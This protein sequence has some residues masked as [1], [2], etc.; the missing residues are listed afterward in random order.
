MT[1]QE[2]IHEWLNN[3]LLALSGKRNAVRTEIKTEAE[4]ELLQSFLFGDGTYNGLINLLEYY[5]EELNRLKAS[6]FSYPALHNGVGSTQPTWETRFA[7]SVSVLGDGENGFYPPN[8]WG[9]GQDTIQN[10]ADNYWLFAHGHSTGSGGLLTELSTLNSARGSLWSQRILQD[11]YLEY[12]HRDYYNEPH[13]TNLLNAITSIINYLGDYR[14]FLEEF[15]SVLEEISDGY[16]PLFVEPDMTDAVTLIP[17]SVFT[18]LDDFITHYTT[19]WEE[20]EAIPASNSADGSGQRE[21]IDNYVDPSSSY[22][23][24]IV[25]LSS[26]VNTFIGG[27]K[28]AVIALMGLTDISEGI[29]KWI[30]FWIRTLI[31]KPQSPYGTLIGVEQSKANAINQLASTE[32]L[33][34]VLFAENTEQYLPTPSLSTIYSVPDINTTA[35]K[36]VELFFETIP[37]VPVTDFYRRE[38]TETQEIINENWTEDLLETIDTEDPS[39]GFVDFDPPSETGY[40][41]YRVQLHDSGDHRIDTYDTSSLQSKLIGEEDIAFVVDEYEDTVLYIDYHDFFVGQIL[42]IEGEGL[43]RVESVTSHSIT[44]HRSVSED[45]DVRRTHGIIYLDFE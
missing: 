21:L 43:F 9:Y 10:T 25:N 35:G 23:Y 11:E 27:R 33:L 26:A 24:S 13:R 1:I 39:L 18:D 36:R 5:G 20:L 6:T 37:V 16:N 34:K 29:K 32:D 45:G 31:E 17:S 7:L 4:I 42:Y 12:I 30:Y 22:D 38:L 41:G 28:N 2:K 8:E 40:Y 44:V 14:E 19:M 15:Q 3:R